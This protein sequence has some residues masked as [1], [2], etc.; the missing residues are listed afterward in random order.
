MEKRMSFIQNAYLP[1]SEK[2]KSMPSS[3]AR[4][5]RPLRPF[6]RDASV[7]TTSMD[8][9]LSLSTMLFESSTGSIRAGVRVRPYKTTAPKQTTAT[10]AVADNIRRIYCLL[11]QILRTRVNLRVVGIGERHL[12]AEYEDKGHR[13]EGDEPVEGVDEIELERPL[14]PQNRS[15]PRRH[16]KTEPAPQRK[17][18]DSAYPVVDVK[19]NADI[20]HHVRDEHAAAETNDDR[21]RHHLLAALR[22]LGRHICEAHPGRTEHARMIPDPTD[23]DRRNACGNYRPECDNHN[24]TIIAPSRPLS[25]PPCA[26]PRHRSLPWAGHYPYSIAPMPTARFANIQSVYVTTIGRSLCARP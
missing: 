4:P 17:L 14:L 8:T 25:S 22:H 6:S 1:S 20:I 23:K 7:P 15:Y 16:D 21:Q 5:P 11:A 9:S 13:D 24:K 26:L 19:C 18:K 2:T 3:A 10:T 12:R